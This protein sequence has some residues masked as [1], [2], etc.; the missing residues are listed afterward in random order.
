[1]KV[2]LSNLILIQPFVRKS[3]ILK[4]FAKN[5][6]WIYR[7]ISSQLTSSLPTNRGVLISGNP[8]TGK[9]AIILNLVERSSFGT[10]GGDV[11][12]ENIYSHQGIF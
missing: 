8:G 9:T 11:R 4:H 7:E 6:E 3:F 5:R 12:Q 10:G 1:M 2:T